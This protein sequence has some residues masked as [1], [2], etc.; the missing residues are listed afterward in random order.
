MGFAQFRLAAI[1]KNVAHAANLRADAAQLLFDVLVTAVNVIHTVEDGF[2][3]RNQRCQHQRSDRAG[4]SLVTNAV[5]AR[6]I[7][8]ATG[9][10]RSRRATVQNNR[11]S[12][13]P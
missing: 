2:A 6:F 12:L 4:W 5:S 9:A 8:A 7:S 10:A 1:R 13:S 11:S 3:I